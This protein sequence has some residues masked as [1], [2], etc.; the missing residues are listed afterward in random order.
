MHLGSMCRIKSKKNS[1]QSFMVLYQDIET[2]LK[3][4]NTNNSWLP[5]MLTS[6]LSRLPLQTATMKSTEEPFVLVNEMQDE[7]GSFYYKCLY[8]DMFGWI[9]GSKKH[10]DIIEEKARK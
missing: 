7:H 5:C 3:T 6:E 1:L 9:I 2:V 8:S 4:R 10:F